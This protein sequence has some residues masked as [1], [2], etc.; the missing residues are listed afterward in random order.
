MMGRNGIRFTVQL[1]LFWASIVASDIGIPSNRGSDL[2]SDALHESHS[3][4]QSQSQKVPGSTNEGIP[5][6]RSNSTSSKDRANEELSLSSQFVELS[7]L[8]LR[9]ELPDV[10]F[11]EDLSAYL[12]SDAVYRK[13]HHRKELLRNYSQASSAFIECAVDNAK[14]VLF[15]GYCVRQIDQAEHAW[16]A[17][18]SDEDCNQDILVSDKLQIVSQTR[19][20]LLQLW[21][22]GYCDKCYDDSENFKPKNTTVDFLEKYNETSSCF[23]NN[24]GS[25]DIPGPLQNNLTLCKNCS[26]DYMDLNELYES[27]GNDQLCMDIIDLMNRTRRVW[28]DSGCRQPSRDFVSVVALS[29]FICILPFFFYVTAKLHGTK[30][31]QKLVEKVNRGDMRGLSGS[32]RLYAGTMTSLR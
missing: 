22:D 6:P 3:H 10:D 23:V 1:L 21:Q 7:P 29:I 18:K 17:I 30:K 25:S 13:C 24:G 27:I 20:F 2:E 5:R 11:S 14:P 16:N 12:P 19:S 8:S 28:T 32:A 4:S 9:T 26:K 15:C 31:Q